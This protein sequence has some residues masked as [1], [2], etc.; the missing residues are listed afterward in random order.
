VLADTVR[1]LPNAEFPGLDAVLRRYLD[2]MGGV[3]CAGACI[4]VAGPVRD[5]AASMTNL[6]W[7]IDTSVLAHATGAE[8]AAILND[9]QAQG[10]A[11]GRIAD[12]DIRTLIPPGDGASGDPAATRLVVGVGTGFNAAPVYGAGA[13]RRVEPSESGHVNLVV[14]TEADMSLARWLED[15]HGFPSVEDVLSGR[16]LERLYAWR[17]HEAGDP[18][19]RS[20]AEIVAALEAGEARAAEA[21]QAFTRHLGA[22]CGNLALIH[23]PFGGVYLVGGVARAATPWLDRFGFA[24]AFRDK[25]RFE[26]FMHGFAVHVIEDDFAALTGCAAHLATGARV[27]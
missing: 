26:D 6:D 21:M 10:Y 7:A 14:R 4:A 12:S 17:G 9:L 15:V 24:D 8:H 11:I 25:G 23:L 3:D 2:D 16:G 5:G 20:A 19:E 27:D 18:R 22:V 1:R 13:T